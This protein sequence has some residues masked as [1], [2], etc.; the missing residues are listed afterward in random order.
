[1]SPECRSVEEAAIAGI[2]WLKKLNQ[3]DLV[4]DDVVGWWALQFAGIQPSQQ[5]QGLMIKTLS[6]WSV[7]RANPYTAS[8]IL[9]TLLRAGWRNENLGRFHEFFEHLLNRQLQSTTR[10][11]DAL[12]L[13]HAF[14]EVGWH[15]AAAYKKNTRR[16][17]DEIPSEVVPVA[18]ASLLDE[19]CSS[20]NFRRQAVEL[21]NKSVKQGSYRDLLDW[22]CSYLLLASDILTS[23]RSETS[24]RLVEWILSR[25]EDG[26]WDAQS[27]ENVESTSVTSL[28]LLGHVRALESTLRVDEQMGRNGLMAIRVDFALQ[29]SRILELWRLALAEDKTYER[30]LLLEQLFIQWLSNDDLLKLE[31]HRLRVRG[32]EIDLTISVKAGDPLLSEFGPILV[33]E[34]KNLRNTLTASVARDFAANVLGRLPQGCKSALIATTGSFSRDALDVLDTLSLSSHRVF[35]GAD[36]RDLETA[37]F[38]GIKLSEFVRETFKEASLRAR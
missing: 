16:I 18:M 24:K 35:A 21:L 34:C 19:I 29:Q 23:P 13:M 26:E 30:G 32:G 37:I 28:A 8:V 9:R 38:G 12:W 31:N 1:L 6:A 33:I 20:Q 3:A 14:K 10:I 36:G 7:E 2:R 15:S 4:G 5:Q 22:Q 27:E 17:I 25:Q 11:I